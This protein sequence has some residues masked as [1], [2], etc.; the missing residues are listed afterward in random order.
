MLDKLRI[1]M[2]PT[3]IVATELRMQGLNAFGKHGSF[4]GDED[5]R[6]LEILKRSSHLAPHNVVSLDG[7]AQDIL[8]SA[9]MGWHA[10]VKRRCAHQIR[11]G[12][13]CKGRYS[14][15][16]AGDL[17][18]RV[19]ECTGATNLHRII[20]FVKPVIPGD[21]IRCITSG[22]TRVSRTSEQECDRVVLNTPVVYSVRE[23][24]STSRILRTMHDC[25]EMKCC[26][27]EDGKI[28]HKTMGAGKD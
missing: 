11:K 3:G 24:S 10:R 13:S 23:V 19:D 14:Y 2:E 16:S 9:G 18:E 26:I 22:C 5:I 21:N 8:E 20:L 25:L 27:G 1:L 15:F 6:T 28:I 4:C 12:C 17:L 7:D